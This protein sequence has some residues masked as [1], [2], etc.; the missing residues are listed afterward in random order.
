M[1]QPVYW[2]YVRA[3]H[4]FRPETWHPRWNAA[5][6]TNAAHAALG[7]PSGSVLTETI[8]APRFATATYIANASTAPIHTASNERRLDR[9]HFFSTWV[10]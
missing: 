7:A 9:L 8:H 6:S 3:Y 2:K 1:G 10:S 4:S 5:P